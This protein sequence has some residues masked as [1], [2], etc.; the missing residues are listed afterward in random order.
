MQGKLKCLLF[1]LCCVFIL[2]S[3][4][5]NSVSL[6]DEFKKEQQ[7]DVK[8]TLGNALL[9]AK[10]ITE[11]QKVSVY[12]ELAD[13]AFS[14][15]DFENALLYFKKLEQHTSLNYLP[16]MHFRAIKMQGVV[17]YFQG[18]F[19]QAIVEYSRAMVIVEKNNKQVELAN[20]LSN[21]GLAYFEMNNMELTLEYYLKAKEIYEKKGSAQDQADILLNIAGVYIRLSRYESA[22]LF[23]KE[24]LKVYQKLADTSGIA[25]VN[26]NLG[27]AYYESSQFD[28]ALHYYQMALRYYISTND[29]NKLSTQY[30]NLANINLIL[31]N[32]DVAY[33]QAKLGVQN[34]LKIANHS[35]ELNALHAL[36]KIQFVRGE[37][38]DSQKSL[39]KATDLATQYNS[40]RIKRDAF[41][42]RSLLEASKGNYAEA[43]TLH[44]K[45]VAEQRGINSETITSALAVLQNQFKATQLNQEIQKL[46]QERK[47]QK[48]K[49]SQRSQL[50]VFIFV[51]LF[52]VIVTGTAL[53]RRGAEK[54]AKQLLKEQVAQRTAEL[55]AIAQ[56][57]REANDV[58]S[59]FLAN[60]SHEIRTPLTAILGQTD[61]LING[62]YEPENLQDELKII[63]RHSDHLKSLINDVLDLSKIEANRLELNISC[64]DIVQLVSDVHAMFITQAKAK[65]LQIRFDN[66]VGNAFYTK[67]DLMRV[68]QILIN[69]CANAVKFTQAGQ[70]VVSLNKTEQGLVFIVKDT[71]IGMNSS[72]LKQIFECFSQADNS[73]S[74]RFGGTGLGLSLSQQLASMMGGYISVQS[75]FKRGSQFSLFLPCVEVEK[76]LDEYEHV[77][78]A[79]QVKQLTG[80]VVLAEDHP[81]NRRLISR[82]LRSMGLE[83][84]AVENGE[85]AVEKCLQIYP[86]LVLLDIQMPVMDGR[87]AFSLLQQC[88]FQA[89]IFALTAN[90]MSHEVDDYLAL[91]FT[92]YL[93]KPLDKNAFYNTLAQHLGEAKQE[94]AY[95]AKIDMSDLVT[96][97]KQSFT[98]ESE[99]ISQHHNSNDLEALQKDS[100]RILGAA[101]MFAL[102]DIAKA[103]K[104]LD[105][106]LLNKQSQSKEHIQKLVDELQRVLKKYNE[107]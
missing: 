4:A 42:T 100:H 55:Q 92:G 40:V 6:F 74:R 70:V 87:A 22:I 53:Y 96:S 43:L 106:A 35:L 31:N 89:P 60:I 103:A 61:D 16:D 23:Y 17:F 56:E 18:Y 95:T 86:D 19:Q 67:L 36:A 49:M 88:G 26:N 76:E 57:L 107:S 51:L 50:T 1:V 102:D 77:S 97:F 27:V 78:A 62:L 46:K 41:G 98:F 45:F 82:Y 21:I 9:E 29:Y 64:F 66:H 32:V 13:L 81:D 34:A 72:Q 33:E 83:V 44:E 48:L 39:D 68:K 93:G 101:Q 28:L 38:A 71:G 3:F 11:S 85:Q 10:N 90:A 30:T 79:E 15:D 59:Q 2:P 52:L 80:R 65:H 58:K 99:T 7:W 5:Q 47:V 63:Q 104:N 54:R 94:A 25:Q 105:M 8:L 73:I 84:I 37:L 24:V 12:S 69:L 75:E 91:G 14:S 20:L